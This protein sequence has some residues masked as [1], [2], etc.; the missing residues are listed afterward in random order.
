MRVHPLMSMMMQKWLRIGGR[1][2][3][4]FAHKLRKTFE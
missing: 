4:M 2:G 3:C 1:S